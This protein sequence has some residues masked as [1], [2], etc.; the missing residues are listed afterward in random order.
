M[1]ASQTRLELSVALQQRAD[2]LAGF[3]LQRLHDYARTEHV[4]QD[5]ANLHLLLETAQM[6]R[7]EGAVSP[8]VPEML[9]SA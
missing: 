9:K 5:V 8:A 2:I 7:T 3:L 1:T 6:L 4:M